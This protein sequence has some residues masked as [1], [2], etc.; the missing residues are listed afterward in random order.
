[1]LL[2][3]GSKS[4][5]IIQ[6]GQLGQQS[7]RG[8]RLQNS[9]FANFFQLVFSAKGPE[10]CRG[11]GLQ[12]QDPSIDRSHHCLPSKFAGNME[13]DP[14]VET[15]GLFGCD[16]DE[17]EPAQKEGNKQP[18]F[19]EKDVTLGAH[20]NSSFPI[21]QSHFHQRIRVRE[22]GFHT[23]NANFIWPGNETIAKCNFFSKPFLPSAFFFRNLFPCL[24]SQQ[25][26]GG[27]YRRI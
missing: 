27:P 8:P 24:M 6:N 12:H 4:K 2:H 9:D 16:S 5:V 1:M 19:H 3:D 11:T 21:N 22:F 13:F 7:P 17:D 23:T 10:K 14:P 26:S 18:S 25:I 20:V 15:G